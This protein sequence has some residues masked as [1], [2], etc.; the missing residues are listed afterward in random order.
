MYL[1]LDIGGTFIK[2]AIMDSKA[3]IYHKNKMPTIKTSLT[4]FEDA[5]V[6]LYQK[7]E[8]IEGIAIS[9]PGQIDVEKGLIYHGGALPFLHLYTASQLSKRCHDIPVAIEN[10]GKCAGLAEASIGAAKEYQDAVVMVF[11]TGIG[12]AIIKN[13]VVHHGRRLQAGE[14]SF[15][16][17]NYMR[18]PKYR[19]Q[20]GATG[21]AIHLTRDLAK[22]KGEKENTYT[23][24]D[25]FSMAENGDYDA[26]NILED[27]YYDVA[28]QIYNM[29]YILDPD[30]FC[31]GGG[32]S[33]QPALLNG[34]RRYIDEIYDSTFQLSKPNVVK[35]KFNN[36]SNLIGALFNFLQIYK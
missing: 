7:Y 21:N 15:L 29:H 17:T 35:C 3:N 13:K 5:I 11:G 20:W 23:G 6:G 34:I 25:V 8:D 16:T 2:Y 33:E 28:N 27:F 36:D 26:I 1:V 24:E 12:G 10:D 30:I 9:C 14:F 18:E 22:V 31:I 32:I 19:N 4:D